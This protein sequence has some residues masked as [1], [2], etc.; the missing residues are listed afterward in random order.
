VNLHSLSLVIK[1]PEGRPRSA[2]RV[3][4]RYLR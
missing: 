1:R 4:V 2:N 3:P